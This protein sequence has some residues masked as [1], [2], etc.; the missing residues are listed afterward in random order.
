[1]PSVTQAAAEPP[2]ALALDVGSSSVRA[3]V[4]DRLGRDVDGMHARRPYTM[5]TTAG[6]GVEVAAVA[7][8]ALVEQSIDELV[9]LAGPLAKDIATVGTSTFWHSVLAIAA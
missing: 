7:L 9:E 2:L 1:M 5:H 6:G 4:F 8:I 3:M